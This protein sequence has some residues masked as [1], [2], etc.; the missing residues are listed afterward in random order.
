[1][2]QSRPK[3]KLTREQ[4]MDA[5][6]AKANAEMAAANARPIPRAAYEVEPS[7]GVGGSANIK[8][9]AVTNKDRWL[10]LQKYPQWTKRVCPISILESGMR[11]GRLRARRKMSSPESMR[12]SWMVCRIRLFAS[13]SRTLVSRL[14]CVSSRRRLAWTGRLLA[15]EISAATPMKPT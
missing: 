13:G 3:P 5:A 14:P 12:P 8:A 6:A 9:Y 7:L 1:M 15:S 2:K 4:L 10:R 11:F